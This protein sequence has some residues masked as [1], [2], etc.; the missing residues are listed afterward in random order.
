MIG[1]PEAI[2]RHHRFLAERRIAIAAH[3][4]IAAAAHR[5]RRRFCRRFRRRVQ[6]FHTHLAS[7]A[8]ISAD[9][10]KRPIAYLIAPV[11]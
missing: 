5:S 1:M 10:N 3:S 9:K 4:T 7:F 8:R 2:E 6:H 11:K